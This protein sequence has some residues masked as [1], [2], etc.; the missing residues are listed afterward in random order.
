MNKAFTKVMKRFF[1]N[2]YDIEM[3]GSMFWYS[4][5]FTMLTYRSELKDFPLLALIWDRIIKGGFYV[6]LEVIALMIS[7]AKPEGFEEIFKIRI[8]ILTPADV[9]QI[10][11]RPNSY[12]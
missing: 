4:G 6:L 3:Y 1:P 12:Y 10:Q 8:D 11:I 2:S 7:K 9:N 5:I